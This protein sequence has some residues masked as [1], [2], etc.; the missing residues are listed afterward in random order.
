MSAHVICE[1]DTSQQLGSFCKITVFWAL[2]RCGSINV[3]GEVGIAGE[4]EASSAHEKHITCL[5][6]WNGC[7]EEPLRH[8]RLVK[9]PIRNPHSW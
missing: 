4:T 7:S 5:S 3:A 2:I 1:S 6:R 9:N 8:A